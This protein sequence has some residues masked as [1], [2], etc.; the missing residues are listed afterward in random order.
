MVESKGEAIESKALDKQN[1]P[2]HDQHK[3]LTLLFLFNCIESLPS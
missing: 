2:G 1:S 3:V